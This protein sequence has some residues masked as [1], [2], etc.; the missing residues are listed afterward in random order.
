MMRLMAV[1]ALVLWA[2]AVHP[3]SEAENGALLKRALEQAEA[4]EWQSSARIAARIP[5]ESASALIEW[6]RLRAGEGD[7]TDYTQFLSDYGDWPGLKLLRR[8]GE[9]AIPPFYR[10]SEVFAYFENQPPQ[11]GIGAIRLAEAHLAR[12][13]DEDA[14]NVIERAWTDFTLTRE[15]EDLIA[16]GYPEVV[17]QVQRKRL[18]NLL[19]KGRLNEA[20]RMLSRVDEGYRR[21]A[22]ARIALQAEE[23]GVDARIA[24]VPE[25]WQNHPGLAFDRFQW[26]IS[27]GRWD[28]AETF[29]TEYARAGAKLGEPE[30]WANRRRGFARRAMRAERFEEAY[31]IATAHGLSEGSHYA[32]LEWLAG[33]IALQ[34]LNRPSIALGHFTKFNNAVASPI[35]KSRAGYW[36]GRTFDALGSTESAKTAYEAAATHQ[37]AYY[38]QLAA[39]RIDADPDPL[40]FN[41]TDIEN[42]RRADFIRNPAVQAGILLIYAGEFPQARRFFAHLAETFTAEQIAQLGDLAME[43]GQPYVALGVAKQAALR[44]IIAPEAYFPVT[45]LAETSTSLPPEVVMAIARRESELRVDAASPAGALGLMQLMPATARAMSGEINVRYSRDKLVEDWRYNAAL[46]TRYLS[47]M[48]RRY[49]GSYVLAFVAYNAGPGRADQWIKEYGDPRDPQVDV[50]DWVEGIPFRE[51]RN[52]VMRVMESLYVY[53]ARLSGNRPDL[54]ISQDL[55]EGLGAF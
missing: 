29:L 2:G 47:Q 18:N 13:E 26:R 45:D 1:L 42:W 39:E 49:D 40:L 11:S 10:P 35:S 16:A 6:T 48:L 3:Q 4:G 54:R 33:Y 34:K 44:G 46:G 38:G 27:K 51:T 20:R 24:A 15:E 14:A 23:N 31:L 21:L 55:K 22:E 17:T 36:L 8:R 30:E 41:G 5:D 37:T 25:V 32:D 52:Y 9:A 50:V 7:F 43:L 19:W 53:R 28:D 12:G